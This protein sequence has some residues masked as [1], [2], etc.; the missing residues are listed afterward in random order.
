M[1]T[2]RRALLP[3]FGLFL[4]AQAPVPNPTASTP[5][6]LEKSNDRLPDGRS[7][8]NEMLK[9]EFRKTLNEL[10][11]MQGLLNELVEELEKNEHHVLPMNV[12]KRLEEFEKTASR[13]RSRLKG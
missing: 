1:R 5:E 6:E 8:R 9:A 13:V 3:A 11:R 4:A 10:H 2:P 7:R 12:L